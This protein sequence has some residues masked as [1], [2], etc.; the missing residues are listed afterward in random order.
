M[1]YEI[2]FFGGGA[3]VHIWIHSAYLASKSLNSILLNVQ[4]MTKKI[5]SHFND[6]LVS[7]NKPHFKQIS[8]F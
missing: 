6:R 1:I 3:L 4:E 5:P 7:F 2:S 8:D